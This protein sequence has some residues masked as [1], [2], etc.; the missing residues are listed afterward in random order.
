MSARGR[1]TRGSSCT[2]RPRPWPVPWPNALTQTVRLEDLTGRAIHIR[3]RDAR[4]HGV[5]CRLLRVTHRLVHA[6][7]FRGWRRQSHR[8]RQVRAVSVQDPA[9]V[10]HDEVSGRQQAIAR[11]IVRQGPV[12]AR[13]DDSYRR[14]CARIRRRAWPRRSVGNRTLADRR[15]APR[16]MPPA[17]PA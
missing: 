5:N 7:R 10:Q 6:P 11:A 16:R 15:D 2:S 9:K 3:G 13:R 14:P 12:G 1:V 8:P 4:L 17:P